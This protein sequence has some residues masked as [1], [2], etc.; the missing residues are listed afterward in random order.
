MEIKEERRILADETA[1]YGGMLLRYRL[2]DTEDAA[3]RFHLIAANGAEYAEISVGDDICFAA[4][5]YRSVRDGG[6]T[7]CTLD[8]IVADLRA[9]TSNFGKAL[10]K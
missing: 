4:D 8:E 6:V 10:Y 9:T 1:L 3:G 5:C 2:I 7:P